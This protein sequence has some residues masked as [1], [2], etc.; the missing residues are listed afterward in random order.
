MKEWIRENVDLDEY[1]DDRDRLEEYLNDEP[2][3]EDSVTGNGSG[4]YYFSG[5]RS[6]EQVLDNMDLL[7]EAYNYFG[8]TDRA[9]DDFLNER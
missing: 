3:A 1:K 2:W 6:Q 7:R 8:Q 5:Y 4:S 9:G